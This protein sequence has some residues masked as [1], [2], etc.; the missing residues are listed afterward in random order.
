MVPA[1]FKPYSKRCFMLYDHT[2]LLNKSVHF[3]FF[4]T[5]YEKTAKQ[6]IS[7]KR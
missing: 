2:I 1:H 4:F 3:H 6:G 7:D 5:A